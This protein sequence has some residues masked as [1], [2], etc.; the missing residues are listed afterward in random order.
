VVQSLDQI[1]AFRFSVSGQKIAH[2]NNVTDFDGD[3][4]LFQVAVLCFLTLIMGDHHAISTF[5]TI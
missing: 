5:F 3:G 2:L 4:P 1:A